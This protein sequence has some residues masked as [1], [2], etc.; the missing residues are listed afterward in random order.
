M[1]VAESL[2]TI[3]RA[4]ERLDMRRH[5]NAARLELSFNGER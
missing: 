4:L 3:E 2:V 5:V 1:A